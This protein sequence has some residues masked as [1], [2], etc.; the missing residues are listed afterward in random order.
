LVPQP[1]REEL[2]KMIEIC[3]TNNKEKA[4]A[5][6]HAIDSLLALLTT[7]S[8]KRH[9]LLPLGRFRSRGLFF[10]NARLLL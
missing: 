5:C 6:V 3:E 9:I 1:R 7:A 4:R 2:N 10:D 8:G